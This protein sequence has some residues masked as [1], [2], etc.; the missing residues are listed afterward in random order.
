VSASVFFSY[1]HEDEAQRDR[2]EKHLALLRR[3]GLIETWY[4]RRILPGDDFAQEIDG[5]INRA[6]IILLLV[7]ASF[8]ASEYC[9][10]IEMARAMERH[11]EGSAVVIP[12]ILRPCH[13]TP[14]PFGKLQG[15]P[16]DA[17]PISQWAE[18]DE[19]CTDVAIQLRKLLISRAE[20]W[21]HHRPGVG[22]PSIGHKQPVSLDI[23]VLDKTPTLGDSAASYSPA[24]ANATPAQ[25]SKPTNVSTPS[26]KGPRVFL[27]FGWEDKVVATAIAER[28]NAEGIEVWFAEWEVFYGESLR[29]RIDEGLATSTHFLVLLSSTSVKK[30]WVNEEIDAAF[31]SYLDGKMRLIPLRLN[32]GVANLPPLLRGK[33]SP[34]ID[35]NALDVSQLRND[36]LGV[37]RRPPLGSPTAAADPQGSTE[38]STAGNLIAKLFVEQSKTGRKFDPQFKMPDLQAATG[39]SKDDIQDVL[40]ELGSHLS[41]HPYSGGATVRANP[42]LF[43]A[44]DS[45]WMPWNPKDDAL[46][47]AADLMNDVDFPSSPEKIAVRYGWTPRRLNPAMTYLK[48]EGAVEISDSGMG[49]DFVAFRIR[50]TDATRRFLKF[51]SS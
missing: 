24:D 11:G 41:F 22:H 39:L 19:G 3:E 23:E 29:R 50:A 21:G 10:S 30:A 17:K 1:S 51:R 28:L 9:Y 14:A 18:V 40:E 2:L 26:A 46:R 5:A 13:W 20:G 15:L 45:W 6:D 43:A 49:G 44:Y 37:S 31:F 47:L 35:A 32:L 7:S 25:S 12:V 34:E 27:S 42:S 36:I 4:D 16:K 33:L 8:I 38:L 48:Q